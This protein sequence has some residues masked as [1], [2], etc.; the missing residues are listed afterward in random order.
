MGR[1]R[2]RT[3]CASAC[4]GR[5]AA[6]RCARRSPCVRL[7]FSP[8][9]HCR[10][11]S[12]M[13]ERHRRG[14]LHPLL[15]ALR[16]PKTLPSCTGR[17]SRRTRRDQRGAGT[18][19]ASSSPPP[20]SQ[21]PRSHSSL[22]TSARSSFPSNPTSQFSFPRPRILLARPVPCSQEQSPM[23]EVGVSK[24]K[25]SGCRL[26]VPPNKRTDDEGM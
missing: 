6:A 4:R 11:S 24:M 7:F 2:G 25:I 14:Y 23:G 22:A 20:P 3:L 1:V 17:Y 18:G 5:S 10:A 13:T 8:A 12:Q 21:E 9:L 26:A 15:I 16:F 19:F